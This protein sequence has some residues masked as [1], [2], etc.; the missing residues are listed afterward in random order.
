MAPETDKAK[1]LFSGTTPDGLRL[2]YWEAPNPSGGTCDYVRVLNPE[3][4]PTRDGG[5]SQCSRG[6]E[7]KVQ[8]PALWSDVDDGVL[9]DWVAVY[10]RAPEGAVSVKITWQG[11]KTVG[12]IDVGRDR[13]FLTFLPYNSRSNE[14][15]I[16]L[17]R[18][19]AFDAHGRVVAGEHFE[20]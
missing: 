12:P 9:S 15:W 8:P 7:N 6:A 2:E 5:W 1:M 10:G 3:G 17:Y 14:E 16:E 11:G 20:H 4:K 13:Y 19:Q 18:T